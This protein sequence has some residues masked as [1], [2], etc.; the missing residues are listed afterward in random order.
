[1]QSDWH[2]TLTKRE[3]EVLLALSRGGGIKAAAAE[4]SISPTT[5]RTHIRRIMQRTGTDSYKEALVRV[6]DAGVIKPDQT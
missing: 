6:I 5:V 2:D 4:L 1:V 3:R